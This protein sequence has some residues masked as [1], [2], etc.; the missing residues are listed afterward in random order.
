MT[1]TPQPPWPALGHTGDSQPTR[2]KGQVMFIKGIFV[3]AL[4]HS[5]GGARRGARTGT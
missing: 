4:A 3:A 1:A 5:P 2:R